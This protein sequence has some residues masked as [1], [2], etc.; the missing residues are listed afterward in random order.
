MVEVVELRFVLLDFHHR[1]VKHPICL[2]LS[3]CVSEAMEVFHHLNVRVVVEEV[4]FLHWEV[5]VG[6]AELR[7]QMHGVEAECNVHYF[8]D[9]FFGYDDFFDYD[10]FFGYDVVVLVLQP[11]WVLLELGW[12]QLYESRQ[13]EFL[14]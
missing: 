14:P 1:L 9:D 12:V 7:N 2:H 10:D 13:L 11:L 5:V 3:L 4:D 6:V 8:Y